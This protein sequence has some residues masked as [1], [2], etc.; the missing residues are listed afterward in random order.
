M[1]KSQILCCSIGLYSPILYTANNAPLSPDKKRAQILRW[2]RSQLLALLELADAIISW[3]LGWSDG[4][5]RGDCEGSSGEQWQRREKTPTAFGPETRRRLWL[6]I[7]LHSPLHSPLSTLLSRVDI[8]GAVCCTI[9][10]MYGE[11]INYRSKG[12]YW[13]TI[14]LHIGSWSS[15]SLHL[16]RWSSSTISLELGVREIWREKEI[17]VSSLCTVTNELSLFTLTLTTHY[18]LLPYSLPDQT[19]TAKCTIVLALLCGIISLCSVLAG[20]SAEG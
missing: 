5:T 14:S 18:Q 1:S 10:S 9:S 19:M 4:S 11:I 16:G 15:I 20:T 8:V 13:S 7:S 3:A 12:W 2:W 6:M 17:G